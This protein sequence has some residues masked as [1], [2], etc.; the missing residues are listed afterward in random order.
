MTLAVGAMPG[1]TLAL[2]ELRIFS[3]LSWTRILKYFSPFSRRMEKCAQP[4][5]QLAVPLC[6][7]RTWNWETL[8]TA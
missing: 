4:M 2:G 5:L 6:A 7:A 1:S 3:T 8:L